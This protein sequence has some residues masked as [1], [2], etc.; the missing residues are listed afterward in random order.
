LFALLDQEERQALSLMLKHERYP[1]GA[2]IFSYGDSGDR[3]FIL[4]EGKV[5]IFVDS[6]EG[7]RIPLAEIVRGDVFGE[8]SLFDGGP[9]TASA[10]ATEET[11]A[12]TLDRNGL[13]HLVSKHPHAALDLLTATGSRLRKTDEMLRSRVTRNVN[14][15]V[16]QRLTLGDHIADRVASFGG[17]WTFI[18]LFF[19]FLVAWVLVNS[20]FLASDSFD[21][22][23]YILLNLFLSMVAAM[24]A[25]VIMMS[26]NRH[27]T[28]DRL[29]ADLDYQV[30]L[31]AELEVAH[32]HSKVDR[33]NETLQALWARQERSRQTGA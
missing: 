23:P 33:I 22:Y 18:F 9:R 16:E 29:M 15:V 31:K 12:L 2:T 26:Q 30:N 27:T 3:L 10:L 8:I 21:P 32:L 20:V 24:Q 6:L 1:K 19:G 14:E 11:E 17:S 28:K 7:H 25:P 4:S 13:L 5:E